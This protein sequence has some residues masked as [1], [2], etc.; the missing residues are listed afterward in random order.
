MSE[1]TFNLDSLKGSVG[2][3][4]GSL[5]AG[6]FS[7]TPDDKLTYSGTDPIV[8]DRTNNERLRRGL[9][10]LSTPRPVDDGKTYSNRPGSTPNSTSAPNRP[11]TEEEK[12]KAAAIAK[13]FGVPDPTAISKDFVLSGPPGMTQDQAFEIFK[14]QA[15]AG[16]LN[17][18][19]PG[20]VLS[21]QTQAKDGLE[22]AKAELSQGAAGFP[23]TDTGVLNSF[24]S[25]ADTAK[26]SIAAGT[27]GT[28]L[29]GAVGAVGSIAKDTVGK[30]S[31]LFGAPVT[32]GISTADFAKTASALAPIS[33]LTTTDVRATVA[34]VGT[35]TGQDFSQFT[36]AVGTGKYGF[37]ATQLETAGLLK[38]GTAS[39][40]LGQGS[41]ELTDVLKSPAV[42]TGKGGINNLDSLLSNPAAQ[43][44]TQQDLMS[45]GLGAAKS[46]GVP[47]DGLNPK[48]LGGVA[49]NFGK[50]SAEGVDWIKGQLPADKQADF[51]T[52]FAD[53]KFAVGTA[54]QKLNEPVKQEA[55]PGESENTVNRQTVDAATTRVVGNDKVPSFN[56]GP[57]PANEALVAENKLLRKEVRELLTRLQEFSDSGEITAV[58]QADARNAQLSALANEFSIV[59]D[60]IVAL[61]ARALNAV[62]YSSDFMIKLEKQIDDIG[63]AISLIN[64][65]QKYLRQVKRRAQQQA[66]G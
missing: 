8:W 61:K 21:A 52:R 20:D 32:A 38:P 35:A 49:A 12:A 60:K 42:W 29:S 36:N 30:I 17:G 57:Q 53:A 41:N 59:R 5:E 62:P 31:G 9:S 28:S 46:L 43:N 15:N 19:S 66:A 3:S 33:N 1:F 63:T 6:L 26:Q 14:K 45:K 24:K 13:Q 23:G 11:L 22:A 16:G 58:D 51:D 2:S 25:I 4:V 34:S 37:N 50:S 44:F 39:T 10:P 40:F 27:T 56:Y 54:E 65:L 7:K 47:I 48:D 18:F 64:D 55:P